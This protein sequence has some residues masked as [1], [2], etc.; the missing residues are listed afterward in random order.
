M[1]A[2][3]SPAATCFASIYSIDFFRTCTRF[4]KA[5]TSIR[6]CCSPW[7]FSRN[8]LQKD[9]KSIS[10]WPSCTPRTALC[11]ETN[12]LGTMTWQRQRL[13]WETTQTVTETLKT[14][15]QEFWDVKKKVCQK[16]NLDPAS[17]TN[18]IFMFIFWLRFFSHNSFCVVVSP[19]VHSWNMSLQSNR[20][21]YEFVHFLKIFT[22]TSL[23]I[24]TRGKIDETPNGY[25][26]GNK[27]QCRMKFIGAASQEEEKTWRLQHVEVIQTWFHIQMHF[28][29]SSQLCNGHQKSKI[30]FHAKMISIPS[31]LW[32]K[33]FWGPQPG[34]SIFFP[35]PNSPVC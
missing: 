35:S 8:D 29:E 13:R 25:W 5:C 34:K 2:D 24:E 18:M 1:H 15:L 33:S 28:K 9:E 6:D 3:T 22:S 26:K 7:H 17:C 4:P 19:S 12:E 31:P 21:N 10:D 11:N 14:T 32:C 16:Q 27:Y 30:R 20:C 23:N